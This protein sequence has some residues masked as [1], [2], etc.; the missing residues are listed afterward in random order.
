MLSFVYRMPV[1]KG[2]IHL[3]PTTLAAKLPLDLY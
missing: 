3:A 2:H 1:G